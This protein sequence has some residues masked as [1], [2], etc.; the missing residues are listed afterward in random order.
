MIYTEDL[1]NNNTI[2][3]F[4]DGSVYK[5]NQNTTYS[6][7]ANILAH[8]NTIYNSNP[9]IL[10]E[11]TNNIGELMAI[12]QGIYNAYSLYNILIKK[13]IEIKYIYLFSDSKY[14]IDGL[15]SWLIK[16]VYNQIN[17]ELI[18]YSGKPVINQNIFQNI[19]QLILQLKIP[20]RL[21]KT[22]GHMDCNSK[23]RESNF[24]KLRNY[25]HLSNY[26][27]LS[28]DICDDIL[29][30]ILIKLNTK[31]DQNAYSVF[32]NKDLC[33]NTICANNAFP[34]QYMGITKSQ[35]KEY[36]NIINF[37]GGI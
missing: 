12:Y 22:R 24:N 19:I 34:I 31:V 32:A 3:V 33:L 4:T 14:C 26:D 6:S 17:K 1:F 25:L 13:G 2:V 9:L 37:K 8:K 23:N 28:M 29:I 11:S 10:K 35:L 27:I 20:I 18:G 15:T 5:D 36:F 7:S 16:W 21:F 30:D